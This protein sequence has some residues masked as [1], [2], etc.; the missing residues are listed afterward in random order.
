MHFIITMT[1][2]KM[3]EAVK[4]G[5]E[6]KFKLTSKLSMANM[7]CFDEHGGAV[8]VDPLKPTLKPPKTKR[9]KLKHDEPPLNLLSNF[10][11]AATARCDYQVPP[12]RGHPVRLRAAAPQG[13]R[14]APHHAHPPGAATTALTA[15]AY[16]S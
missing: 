4:E 14:G 9:L 6:K 5:I 11:C 3:A 1:P 2:E 13:V 15:R 16:I 7:H 12:R 8:Q 10:S